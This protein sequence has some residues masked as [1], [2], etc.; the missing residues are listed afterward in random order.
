MRQEAP[1]VRE[2]FYGKPALKDLT[3]PAKERDFISD[4]FVNTCR[5][6]FDIFPSA[7][8]PLL[9][10]DNDLPMEGLYFQITEGEYAGKTISIQRYAQ[11]Q[12]LSVE[13][14]EKDL[15]VVL[16]PRDPSYPLHFEYK[17]SHKKLKQLDS[18]V[19]GYDDS[20]DRPTITTKSHL[21]EIEN[22]FLML[23]LLIAKSQITSVDLPSLAP[24]VS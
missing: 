15:W 14:S 18:I 21:A 23:D 8:V 9:D 24:K 11:D 12:E 19:D 10:L 5:E 6:M 1:V 20:K 7:I 13:R 17:E 4:T 22:V 16:E 3:I 2:F